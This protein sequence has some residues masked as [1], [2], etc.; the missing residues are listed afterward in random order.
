LT[1]RGPLQKPRVRIVSEAHERSHHRFRRFNRH[2]PRNG[3]NGLFRALPGDR[4]CL[5]LLSA[6]LLADVTPASRRQDHTTSHP[7]QHRSSTAETE[8]ETGAHDALGL[9]DIDECRAQPGQLRRKTNLTGAEIV[10][11]IF[12]KAGQEVG[13]GIFTADTDGPSRPRLTRRISSPDYDRRR[14]IIVALPGAAALDVAEEAIP[15]VADTTGNSRQRLDLA[16]IGNAELARAVM[17]ALGIGPGLVALDA[18]HKAASKLIIATGLHAANPAIR[19]MSAERLAEKIAAGRPDN[20]LLLLGPQAARMAAHV[21]AG[22]APNRDDRR[23]YLIDRSSHVG[24]D[25][26]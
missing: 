2:S 10:I 17:A 6:L 18:D 14:P 26:W 13:E 12:D 15:G 5:S 24:R 19:I 3:F 16:V 22:P 7:R 9:F 25:R 23:R 20:P 21:A 4:A 11:I 8:V 1:L